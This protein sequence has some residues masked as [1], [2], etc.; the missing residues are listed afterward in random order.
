M[1]MRL[2]P[3]DRA[4]R[5]LDVVIAVGA[6]GAVLGVMEYA[7]FGFD[8]ASRRPLG[9][10][11]HYMTYS[12]VIMLVLVIAI[13]RLLYYRDQRVWPAV[14][15]PALSVALAV[16][17]TRN[18][19]VG[20]LFALTCLLALRRLRLLVIVPALVAVFFLAAPPALDSRALSIFDRTD[21]SN[22]DRL[23]MLQMGRN[24]TRDH[25]WF[26]VG[27]DAV[28]LVYARYRPARAVHPLNAHLH[29]VPV[30][31]AAERGLPA[32]MAWLTFV[33]IASVALVRQVTHGPQRAVAASGLAV[34]AAMLAAGMFEYNFGDSEFLMLFL[35]LLTLPFAVAGT[36]HRDDDGRHPVTGREGA[37][38]PPHRPRGPH[39]GRG[40]LGR[41]HA[42][43]GDRI[44]Q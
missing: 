10:L 32:L 17:F 7:L 28:K 1:V 13:A 39:L 33:A 9:S 15:I 3:A 44:C 29:N 43:R 21:A 6:A 24:M 8:S 18:A 41:I 25:P 42:D 27:P 38:S 14:A 30:Q 26:G 16:T 4:M 35:G 12:G 37:A 22:Q 20:A 11:T 5:V 31:I 19:W 23:A 36:P 34:M 40:V 2:I